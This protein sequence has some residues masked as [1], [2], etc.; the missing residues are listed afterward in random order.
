VDSS[1]SIEAI[2]GIGVKKTAAAASHVFIL[3]PSV[4]R[5]DPEYDASQPRNHLAAVVLRP[6]QAAHVSR[7]AMANMYVNTPTI[8]SPSKMN[9]L[10]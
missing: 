4:T 7:V 10:N 8:N 1:F 9:S 6:A 2:A 3:T 5:A